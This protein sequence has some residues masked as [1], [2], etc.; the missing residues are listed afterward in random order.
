MSVLPAERE[1][2]PA[3]SLLDL[4]Q[5]SVITQAIFAAASLG[6]ADVLTDGPLPAREIA[7]RVDADAEATYRLLRMLSGYAVFA[8]RAD[9]RFELTPMAEALRDDAPDS[10]RGIA[11]LMG[12]PLLWEDWGHLLSSVRTGEANMPKLRGMGSFD[13]L[14]SHPDYAMSFFAGMGSLS[15]PETEPVV[16]AYDFSRFG[17][18]VDVGGGRRLPAGRDSAARDQLARHSL[19]RAARDRQGRPAIRGDRRG[20]PVHY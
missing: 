4:I 1:Q 2:S 17:T 11:R 19:R 18:I 16:A 15:R 13:F 3:F 8:E 9:G 12:H 6:I 5:G 14:M 7:K 10:M 20:R